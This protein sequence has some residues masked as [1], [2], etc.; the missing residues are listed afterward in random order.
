[1]GVIKINFDSPNNSHLIME[2]LSLIVRN[3][4]DWQ[5]S[6]LKCL[7]MSI[8]L[9]CIP[10]MHCVG[11]M[12]CVSVVLAF[13]HIVFFL[14]KWFTSIKV[15]IVICKFM[16]CFAMNW[17]HKIIVWSCTF[18][19]MFNLNQAWLICVQRGAWLPSWNERSMVA[20]CQS[21]MS[22]MYITFQKL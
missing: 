19:E 9:C 15:W 7:Q 22:V 1:M 2:V 18:V 3:H 21:V 13:P 6:I 10:F 8:L 20:T 11:L 4:S 12:L 14:P 16:Q 17:D 5:H